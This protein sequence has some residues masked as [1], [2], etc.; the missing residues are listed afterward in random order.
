[1]GDG[2]S[3]AAIPWYK[4]KTGLRSPLVCEEGLASV[5]DFLTTG[6]LGDKIID[7]FKGSTYYLRVSQGKIA[8]HPEKHSE[9]GV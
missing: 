8:Q 3:H 2:F 7:P 1:M 9:I 4:L 5:S 6:V